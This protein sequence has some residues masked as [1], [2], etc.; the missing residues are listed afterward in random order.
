MYGFCYSLVNSL[1]LNTF[2]IRF[3]VLLASDRLA[4]SSKFLYWYRLVICYFKWHYFK[5]EGRGPGLRKWRGPGW[6]RY[7]SDFCSLFWAAHTWY[8]HAYIQT[9]DS[10]HSTE[11]PA[12][13]GRW[14]ASY[15]NCNLPSS[16]RHALVGLTS[17]TTKNFNTRPSADTET[18]ANKLI[19]QQQ[20]KTA[21]HALSA[22]EQRWAYQPRVPSPSVPFSGDPFPRLMRGSLGPPKST[23]QT[24]SLSAHC[25]DQRTH[26]PYGITRCYLPPD[27]GDIPAFTPAEVG[28]RL[29]DAGGCKAELT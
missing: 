10:A 20:R 1:I 3:V 18:E 2:S 19:Q 28:M 9:L 7:A 24:A 26:R 16:W 13:G 11:A 17:P 27:R 14:V 15:C 4:R 5:S 8:I 12:P 25:H 22:R 6:L 23:S 21:S 29:N